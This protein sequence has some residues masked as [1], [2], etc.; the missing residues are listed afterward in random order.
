MIFRQGE[1]LGRGHA[2][3][4]KR[5]MGGVVLTPALT[6]AARGVLDGHASDWLQR[7]GSASLQSQTSKG[8]ASRARHLT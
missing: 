1:R 5:Y 2:A 8:L 7:W 4:E 3:D 6:I